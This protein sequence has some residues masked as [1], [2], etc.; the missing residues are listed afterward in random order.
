M[1]KGS[2]MRMCRLS[3]D[4]KT[5]QPRERAQLSGELLQNRYKP[6]GHIQIAQQGQLLQWG[7]DVTALRN[8]SRSLCNRDSRLMNAISAVVF[9]SK[10]NFSSRDTLSC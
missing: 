9:A 10:Y 6:H 2:P 3:I 7:M 4:A 5:I 8:F 1:K